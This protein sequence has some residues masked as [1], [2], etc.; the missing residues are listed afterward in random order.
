MSWF[1]K[2]KKIF[3]EEEKIEVRESGV[4]TLEQ[5]ALKV[6]EKIQEQSEKTSQLKK[7]I[8]AGISQ[9][10]EKI[11]VSIASLEKIDISGKKE[12]EKIKLIVA[13]NLALYVS[14]MKRLIESMKNIENIET[15]EGA[16]RL[17][18]NLNEF[19]RISRAPY[20]KANILIG[21]ELY[22]AREIIRN[23]AQEMNRIADKKELF[24]EAEKTRQLSQMLLE[25]EKSRNYENEIAK[26]KK[27]L[28]DELKEKSE[29]HSAITE[30]IASAKNSA[31]YKK[32]IKEK[33]L[34]QEK[35]RELENELESLKQKINFKQLARN[36]HHDEKK[37][38]II[39]EYSSSFRTSAMNDPDLKII[40]FVKECQNADIS[41]LREL[42]EKITSHANFPASRMETEILLMEKSLKELDSDMNLIKTNIENESKKNE[43][44]AAKREKTIQE[45]RNVSQLVFP[46]ITIS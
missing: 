37:L 23:F 5:I 31:D 44:L 15:K 13:E 20:E 39:S 4:L 35:F 12:H 30:K 26:K 2:L 22:E 46:A 8:L 36:F 40:E 33:E 9:L 24:E 10:E 27:N 29:E 7:E 11:R 38:G 45:I 16:G 17:F 25:L 18:Y 42:K 34:Q 28:D 41:Y 32:D 1:D 6:G 21:K 14:Q 3:T 19:N 43:R